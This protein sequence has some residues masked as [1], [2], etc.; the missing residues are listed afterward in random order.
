MAR[1]GQALILV[2]I[3]LAIGALVLTPMLRY[4]STS[5]LGIRVSKEFLFTQYALDAGAEYQLWQLDYTEN[6][7]ELLGLTETITVNGIAVEV[8]LEVPTPPETEAPLVVGGGK[9]LEIGMESN[10]NWIKY[11]GTIIYTIKFYNVGNSELV[12][13]SAR[14]ILPKGFRYVE[15]S[16]TTDFPLGITEIA[17]NASPYNPDQ[18]QVVEFDLQAAA[19]KRK[20][21]KGAI[22]EAAPYRSISF[23]AVANVDAGIFYAGAAGITEISAK[24]EEG[25]AVWSSIYYTKPHSGQ[26]SCSLAVKVNLDGSV[27]VI[28]YQVE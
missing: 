12:A 24:I 5:L 22:G 20:V 3:A 26:A 14:A 19:T 2:L 13:S 6:P 28:S 15:G 8:G 18:R 10:P 17:V 25:A 7:E 9:G 16:L 27:E 11:K 4:V 1:N 21:P 23:Q